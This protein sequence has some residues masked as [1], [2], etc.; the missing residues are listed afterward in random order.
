MPDCIIRDALI[1]NEGNSFYS[2]LYIRKG[3]IEKISPSISCIKN[4]YSEFRADGKYLIPGVIDA[5]VHF[6]EPGFTDKADIRSESFAA[7]AGG[8]TSFIDMPNTNPKTITINELKRKFSIASASSY[9]NYSFYMGATNNNF[10][11]LLLAKENG[12]A[13]IKVFLGAST[14]NM[15]VD[16][17]KMLEKIFSQVNS[18]IT[19]HAED[20]NIIKNQ[21]AYYKSI[22]G[23]KIPFEKHADIRPSEACLEATKAAVELAR[24][25]NTR[26]HLAHVSTADELPLLD[27][28]TEV[29]KKQ[30]TA[31]VCVNH[32][33]FDKKDY[34][35]NQGLIKCNPS[36]KEEKHR[37]ALLKGLQEGYLDIVATDH[38]PHSLKEKEQDYHLCPSGI[39]FIQHSLNIM[40]EFYHQ[41]LI[42]FYDIVK[43]MCHHPAIV[44]G[45]KDRGFIREG[46]FADLCLIDI[47]KEFTVTK[48]NL[49]Y[50]CGWSPL[51]DKT[52]KSSVFATFVNGQLAWLGGKQIPPSKGIQIDFTD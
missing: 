34:T 6:R 49:L 38:A 45:I 32:L 37:I 7:V 41:Q 4:D 3:R 30:I 43:W 18:I 13:G 36:I 12:A 16:N 26:L 23:D 27:N 51:I 42:T 52:F 24:K 11:E 10:S 50:K 25:Y 2:D 1:F 21:F 19:V 9:A 46:Y 40:L 28:L 31:E 5:H 48:D 39:P 47:Q 44:F 14:G 22:F 8:V 29:N 35:A 15:L 17:N 20:E 33:Y